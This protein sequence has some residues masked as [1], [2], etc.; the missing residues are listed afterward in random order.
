MVERDQLVVD[1]CVTTKGQRM[2]MP[3]ANMHD[4]KLPKRE[5]SPIKGH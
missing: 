2:R 1:V 5:V 3:K 4:E